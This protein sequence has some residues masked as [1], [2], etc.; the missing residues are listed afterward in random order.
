MSFAMFSSEVEGKAVTRDETS[1]MNARR[2]S[3]VD[4]DLTRQNPRSSD[5]RHFDFGIGSGPPSL[6]W[7]PAACGSV[8][9][10]P[11]RLPMDVLDSPDSPAFWARS[12]PQGPPSHC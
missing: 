9:H 1:G 5:R 6:C 4:V 2:T 8:A 11:P 3:A 7:P 12:T 10:F